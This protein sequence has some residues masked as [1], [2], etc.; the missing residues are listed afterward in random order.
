MGWIK[1]KHQVASDESYRDPTNL[2]GKIQK[3]QAFEAELTANKR[4]LDAAIT[5]GN[6]LIGR[7]HF[8]SKDIKEKQVMLEKAWQNLEQESHDKAVKLQ[9][10][11]QV[12]EVYI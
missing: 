12:L 7:S 1:E 2:A 10:A 3:H 5:E 4:R 11:Y 9:Q 8:E 6:E